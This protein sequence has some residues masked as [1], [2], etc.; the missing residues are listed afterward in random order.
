MPIKP[1][2]IDKY[3][4]FFDKVKSICDNHGD[5]HIADLSKSFNATPGPFYSSVLLNYFRKIDLE[6]YECLVGKFERVHVRKIME[7]TNNR[8]KNVTWQK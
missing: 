6:H 2:T 3:L 5:L 8:Y 7:F 1:S 4:L